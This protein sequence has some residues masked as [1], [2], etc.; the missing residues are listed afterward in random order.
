MN[1][2]RRQALWFAAG[3]GA[4][5]SLAAKIEPRRRDGFPSHFDLVT[6]FPAQAGE[7]QTIG[8][9]NAFV[10]PPS[11][12]VYDIYEQVLE[13]T[14]VAPS[15]EAVMLSVAYGSNQS[16]GLEL[17]R[18]EVCYAYGGFA[19]SD[20]T[21]AEIPLRSGSL[22]ATQ[23]LAELPGRSEAVTYWMTLG[24]EHFPDSAAHRLAA[25]AFAVRRLIVE[26]LLVRVSSIDPQRDRAFERNA[27]FVNALVTALTPA[28]RAIVI[29]ATR[30]S[31]STASELSSFVAMQTPPSG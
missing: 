4:V 16:N 24:G 14:Y 6:V 10:R 18:P 2:Q 3:M 29:G 25:L 21:A 31:L 12:P 8:A 17:H 5:A 11:S 28:Q 22:A 13:R 9:L 30:P 26:G 23:L 7:W 19:V 20:V 27:R 15:G 1:R